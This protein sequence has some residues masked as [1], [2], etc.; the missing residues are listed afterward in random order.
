MKQVFFSLFIMGMILVLASSVCN[1]VNTTLAAMDTTETTY[2]PCPIDI[3]DICEQ[4]SG[5]PHDMVKGKVEMILMH[6][7]PYVEITAPEGADLDLI[8]N[9]KVTVE[10][11]GTN[12]ISLLLEGSEATVEIEIVDCVLDC[13]N[14]VIIT[15][16]RPIP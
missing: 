7:Y 6:R 2:V 8:L 10:G 14:S 4:L 13:P 12:I 1:F 9:G 15:H 16:F 3:G 5:P 11:N